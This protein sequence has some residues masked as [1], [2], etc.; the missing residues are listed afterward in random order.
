MFSPRHPNNVISE[1]FDKFFKPV[2]FLF[3]KQILLLDIIVSVFAK[4]L[5]FLIH[6]T[7]NNFIS[8]QAIN[9]NMNTQQMMLHENF[10]T[11]TRQQKF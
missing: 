9:K 7:I 4:S 8:R 10:M 6:K 1:N 2:A 11:R 5:N 3:I